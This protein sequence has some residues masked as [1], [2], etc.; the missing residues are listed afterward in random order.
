MRRYLLTAI[1]LLSVLCMSAQSTSKAHTMFVTLNSS[2]VRAID[3]DSIR[4]ITFMEKTEPYATINA[5][6]A[7]GIYVG[8]NFKAGRGDYYL[9]LGDDSLTSAGVPTSV[10][11]QALRL[12]FVT[13]KAD[14]PDNAHLPSGTYYVSFDSTEVGT[15][16]YDYSDYLKVTGF[17]N[18][19]PRAQVGLFLGLTVTVK[20]TG[21]NYYDIHASGYFTKDKRVDLTYSG[22]I[23]FEDQDPDLPRDVDFTP[24]GLSGN[25]MHVSANENS[26]CYTL[27]FYNVP[28]DD[29]GYVVGAGGILNL[30]VFTQ[31]NSAM[32]FSSLNGTY[33]GADHNGYDWSPGHFLNGYVSTAYGSEHPIGSYYSENNDEGYTIHTGYINDGTVSISYNDATDSITV[34]AN[35]T[36]DNGK[37]ITMNTT[38]GTEGIIDYSAYSAPRQNI[39][40][41]NRETP[42]LKLVRTDALKDAEP[43]SFK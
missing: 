7:Q 9:C 22:V 3:V 4:D 32:D 20:R 6:K 26:D 25:Y 36:A 13:D 10:N 17:S 40:L 2:F 19:R 34:N 41:R 1:A 37:K 38:I 43:L 14:D 12:L 42:L 33:T 5:T 28:I 27:A 18:N 35:L 23:N 8:D 39:N 30:M 15:I 11:G 16:Y 24:T 29:Q 31:R 21:D